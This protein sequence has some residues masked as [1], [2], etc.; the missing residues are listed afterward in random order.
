[1]KN[2]AYN[3]YLRFLHKAEKQKKA[4]LNEARNKRDM[5]MFLDFASN[6]VSQMG[7]DRGVRFA[8]P[9]SKSSAYQQFYANMQQA[10]K[11]GFGDYKGRILYDSLSNVYKGMQKRTPQ[12]LKRDR[13]FIPVVDKPK[14]PVLLSGEFESA[15][16]EFN[17]KK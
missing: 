2:G 3:E 12:P 16:K 10:Y 13:T 4:R 14:K 1:M 9:A 8:Q 17:S 5:A 15:V 7:N 6:L 11:S